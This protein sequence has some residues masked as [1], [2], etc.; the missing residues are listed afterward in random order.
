MIK[1][2]EVSAEALKSINNGKYVEG[3]IHMDEKTGKLVFHAYN[4]KPKKVHNRVVCYLE[5]GWMMESAERIKFYNSIDKRVGAVQIGNAMQRELKQAVTELI[6]SNI[7]A[8]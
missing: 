3:S 7:I 4:R 1:K 8:K 5:H 6:D 2:I